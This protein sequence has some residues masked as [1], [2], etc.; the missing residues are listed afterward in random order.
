MWVQLH[1]LPLAFMHSSI[2]R[3]LGEQLGVVLEVDAGDRGICS[4]RFARIRILHS[5]DKPLV[6]GIWVNL[7]NSLEES[8]ILLLYEKLPNFCFA[9]GRLGHI[10]RDCVKT[11]V[12]KAHL[13]FGNWIRAPTA[14][15]SRRF[16]KVNL[17]SS[18]PGSSS[19]SQEK[20]DP[21]KNLL[22][23]QPIRSSDN[24]VINPE[25]RDF[26]FAAIPEFLNSVCMIDTP[27]SP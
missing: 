18:V 1:N 10:L 23:N 11:R 15:L 5:I 20:M 13:E 22:S 6:K 21:S 17:P 16:G 14:I 8:C 4:G 25:Q 3:K 2:I 7:E 19:S 9:C 26:S 12:D 27:H 24:Q